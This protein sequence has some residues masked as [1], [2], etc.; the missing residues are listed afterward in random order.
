MDTVGRAQV[1][2]LSYTPNSTESTPS[3]VVLL[4]STGRDSVIR[5]ALRASGDI[6]F[7]RPSECDFSTLRATWGILATEQQ[8]LVHTN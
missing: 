5:I 8:A 1:D 3:L 6:S 7:S 2:G 4:I